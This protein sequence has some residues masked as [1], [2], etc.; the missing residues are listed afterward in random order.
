MFLLT[1]PPLRELA[2]VPLVLS[3][4][5]SPRSFGIRVIVPRFM[6]KFL[7]ISPEFCESGEALR[8]MEKLESVPL[9]HGSRRG[10]RVSVVD[11][12]PGCSLGPN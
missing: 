2:M 6:V 3:D 5:V 10:A 11:A 9:R 4:W 7:T 8:V 1:F 12:A